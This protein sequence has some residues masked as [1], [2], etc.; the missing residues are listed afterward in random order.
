MT[1]TIRPSMADSLSLTDAD[2]KAPSENGR[3]IS[4][5]ISALRPSPDCHR[6]EMVKKTLVKPAK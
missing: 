3:A 5:V 2:T 6:I 1:S 4:P